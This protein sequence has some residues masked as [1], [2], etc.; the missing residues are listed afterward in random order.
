MCNY[1]QISYN[2]LFVHIFKPIENFAEKF[3]I[4]LFWHQCDYFC[5]IFLQIVATEMMPVTSY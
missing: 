2:I 4:I 3:I 5:Y 1:K